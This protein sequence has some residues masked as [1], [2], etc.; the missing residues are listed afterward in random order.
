MHGCKK[1]HRKAP[2]RCGRFFLFQYLTDLAY[3]PYLLIF[4]ELGNLVVLHRVACLSF[5]GNQESFCFHPELP[6][7]LFP[8][9]LEST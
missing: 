3:L 4:P 2:A 5:N 7:S 6:A 8:W 1:A 9:G